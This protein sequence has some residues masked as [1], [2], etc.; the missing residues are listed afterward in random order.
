MVAESLD[1]DAEIMQFCIIVF[2]FM[3]PY[4]LAV[5]LFVTDEFAVGNLQLATNCF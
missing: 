3:R 2:V 5:R 1:S 4:A